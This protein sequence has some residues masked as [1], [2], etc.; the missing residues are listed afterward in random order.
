[1]P[2]DYDNS[3]NVIY[4]AMLYGKIVVASRVGGIPELI[5]NGYTGLL[6]QRGNTEDLKLKLI[7][8]I[9]VVQSGNQKGMQANA[10]EKMQSYAGT[11][12][13]TKTRLQLI[14]KSLS[15]VY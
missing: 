9:T 6:F 5:E 13:N 4:E 10:R 2:S 7:E 12:L 3:P 14:K 8:A 1:M 11:E 15:F